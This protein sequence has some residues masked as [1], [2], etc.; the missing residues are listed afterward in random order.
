MGDSR[1]ETAQAPDIVEL[2]VAEERSA[3]LDRVRL[4]DKIT[5]AYNFLLA[6]VWAILIPVS[7]LAPWLFLAHAAGATMPKLLDRTRGR[8]SPLGR[9]LRDIY[10]L[11]WILPFWM[12]LD[13]I[14]RLLHDTAFDRVIG[15]LDLA[16]F[17]V[18]LDA[19][20][21]PAMSAMWFSELMYL[22]YF[23]YYLVVV[24]PLL[25]MAF[26]GGPEMKRDMTFRVV[27]VYLSSFF[28]YIAFPVDG[29]HALTEHFQ[30]AFQQGFFYRIEA[31]LQSQGDALGASF[32]SSHVAASVTMA[33]LGFRWFSKPVAALLTVAALG[34]VLSTV[35]T[36][37]HYAID[38]LAGVLWAFW[39]QLMV[40]PALL[41]W[42]R[43]DRRTATSSE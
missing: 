41:R 13:L 39:I 40:A 29:P 18:H 37:N 9:V 24:I 20:W 7:P 42:W 16:V 43:C 10:P 1:T 26:R 36:Q 11:I 21:L 5:S 6:G 30:G 3:P 23:G 15:A 2:A 17:G 34:V 19:L 8:L 27:L 22:A 12:E 14:R 4:V 31:V 28:V 33:Y 38:S 32:P 35:Y 25:Y